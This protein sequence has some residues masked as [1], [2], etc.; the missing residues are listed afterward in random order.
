MTL[1]EGPT[2]PVLE[3]IVADATNAI[4]RGQ[5]V[6]I[7]AAEEDDLGPHPATLRI[8]RLGGELDHDSLAANLYNALRSLDAEGVDVIFAR[9]FADESGLAAAIHDRLRRAAAGRIIRVVS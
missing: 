1:Y 7:I 3:R 5:R 8:V 6:G 2:R 4:A 9:T